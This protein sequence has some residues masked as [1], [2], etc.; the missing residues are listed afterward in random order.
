MDPADTPQ[1]IRIALL[2]E[3][4]LGVLALA[5]GWLL[6]HSPLVGINSDAPEFSTQ[7][8]AIGWGLVATGPLLLALL[9]IERFPLGPLRQLREMT[10]EVILKMF[11]GATIGQLAAVSLAAGFG[12]ELLFRGLIQA[13]VSSWITGTIGIGV[14]LAVAS[15]LFGICHW[16]SGTYAILAVIAGAYFGLLLILSGNILAPIV[17]HAA[18]DFLALVYLIKPQHLIGSE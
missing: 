12:E 4:G 15:L 8:R 9:T 2:F 3:C 1:T 14:G 7:V 13:G 5:I 16:L 6:G 10:A 18:Y 11:G 17:A